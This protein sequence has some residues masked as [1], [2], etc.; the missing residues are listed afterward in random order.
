MEIN[1]LSKEI[2]ELLKEEYIKEELVSSKVKE[3]ETLIL[4]T[5]W[6]S[7]MCDEID[8]PIE[9]LMDHQLYQDALK[10]ILAIKEKESCSLDMGYYDAKAGICYFELKDYKNAEQC[11]YYAISDD[12]DY[13]DELVPYLEKLRNKPGIHLTYF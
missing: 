11:F 13:I 2:K 10:I 5:N 4:N 8:D 1:K 3:L 9:A 6:Y 7:R 12:D